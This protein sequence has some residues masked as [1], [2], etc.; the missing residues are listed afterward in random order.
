M[1]NTACRLGPRLHV[2]T[3]FN[4]QLH[5]L[6]VTCLSKYKYVQLIYWAKLTCTDDSVTDDV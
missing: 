6:H 3:L 4:T 5:R 1:V 2:I